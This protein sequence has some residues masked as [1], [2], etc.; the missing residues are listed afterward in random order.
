MDE[1]NKGPENPIGALFD[2]AIS[3][4]EMYVNFVAAGFTEQQ[5]L[6]LV[7]QSLR[8]QSNG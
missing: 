8:P 4:H 3:M 7:A 2:A 1:N 5:A 6:Y